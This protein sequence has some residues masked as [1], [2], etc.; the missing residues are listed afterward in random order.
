M[1]PAASAK[2]CLFILAFALPAL[3]AG[4]AARVRNTKAWAAGECR[5]EKIRQFLT[6]DAQAAPCQIGMALPSAQIDAD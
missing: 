3:A 4:R 2:S 5:S 1:R 6:E